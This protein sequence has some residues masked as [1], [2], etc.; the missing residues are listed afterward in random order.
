MRS[1][2]MT[3]A[4]WSGAA[5]R[6]LKT[7]SQTLLAL[8]T[9]D[10]ATPAN[11]LSLDWKYVAV[12]ALMAGFISLLTSVVSGPIGPPGSPSMVNDRPAPI[13]DVAV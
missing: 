3:A 6:S 7:I 13:E 5:E 10:A 11:V 8:L 2:L 1:Y 9:V 4:W 12:G